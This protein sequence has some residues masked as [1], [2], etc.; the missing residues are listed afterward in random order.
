MDI[1]YKVELVQKMQDYIIEN[2]DNEDF[3]FDELY[4]CV[5]YS[6][7]HADR[8]FKELLHRT[9]KEYLKLIRFTNSA[10]KL[11]QGNKKILDTAIENNYDSGE[12]YS[13]AFY[14]AFGKLPSEYKKGKSF[15]P[16]FTYYPIKNYYSYIKKKEN[17]IMNKPNYCII[18]PVHKEKRKLIFM[19][20]K[21]A[22]D[23]F[24]FCNE[25]G[26]DW[27]GLLNSIP[28]KL[29]TAAILTLPKALVKDGFTATACG[30]EVPFDYDGEI[31]KG[32]EAE[33]LDECDMM[34]FQS[35]RYENEEDFSE[36]ISQVFDAVDSFDYNSYGY[37]IDDN[38]APR[39]NFGAE[40]E[41]GARF[42]VPVSKL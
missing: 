26:C 5:G 33:T 20:A 39:F 31:P 12:G 27:E 14:K 21:K 3:S 38:I 30:I 16:M 37:K 11:T 13:K 6:Q 42:A 40:K 9:P 36:M 7:R 29:D 8:C 28:C 22:D 19:R 24:S 34:Y 10:K 2:A 32:F 18:T 35:Q 1:E 17:K 23:Y 25:A 41:T 4:S 15:I